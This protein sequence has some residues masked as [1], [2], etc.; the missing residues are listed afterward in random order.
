MVEFITGIK[1]IG[2]TKILSEAAVI[3]A[4]QSKGNVIYIDCSDKLSLE[5]PSNIRLININDYG[6]K[7]A[8][9][10]YGFLTGL[11][12]GD[13][14]LTDVFVDSTLDIF[15][16]KTTDIND[17]LDIVTRMSNKVGVNFHFSIYDSQ[18]KEPVYQY[19]ND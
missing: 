11:C 9:A 13:Y 4:Q 16:G 14:D 6:I 19:L 10:F 1:G 8:V 3:T 12:A 15:S 17:F 2:K 5:L 7:S 18:E